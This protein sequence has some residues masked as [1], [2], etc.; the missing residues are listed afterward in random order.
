MANVIFRDCT[1]KRIP[2]LSKQRPVRDGGGVKEDR[3]EASKDLLSGAY[4]ATLSHQ[5]DL[6]K[7]FWL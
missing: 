7:F 4:L 6:C 2:V 1:A 3:M 5:V